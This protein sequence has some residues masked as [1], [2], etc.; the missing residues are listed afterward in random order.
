MAPI[1]G[2]PFLDLLLNFLKG[3]GVTRAILS[4]GYM[5]DSITSYFNEHSIGLELI[6]EIEQKPL[7]TG[8][9]IAAALRRASTDKV[10]VFNGDTFL[11]LNIQSVLAMWPGDLSPIV[12]GRSVPNTERFGRMDI[13]GD[14]IASFIGSGHPGEGVVNAGCYLVPRNIF[15]N[16]KLP[17]AFSF[18]RDY[19]E[20][21]PPLSLRT[22]VS[23]GQFI[24]I[25]VPEDYLLAQKEL[26]RLLRARSES[27]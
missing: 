5:A 7:G 1:A 27:Q 20:L 26:A 14:R 16:Q 3:K 18:E 17:E 23:S 8:G 21:L 11:D 15:L 19:L 9:A 4:I 24:D 13:V 6:F 25:G 10:F 22:F 12:V 2:R